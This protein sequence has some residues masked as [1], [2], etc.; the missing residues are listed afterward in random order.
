MLRRSELRGSPLLGPA[1][2]RLAAQGRRDVRIAVL[3]QGGSP[4]GLFPFHKRPG[5]FGRAIGAPFCDLQAM[6]ADPGAAFGLEDVMQAAGLR[7]LRLHA[8]ADPETDKAAEALERE[9]FNLIRLDESPEEYL[10]ARRS[11]HARAFKNFRRLTRVAER[12]RGAI[13]LIGPDRDPA[14]LELLLSWKR[15][16]FRASGYLDLFANERHLAFMRNA[17]ESSDP[18]CEGLLLTLTIG[19]EPVA[20]HFGVRSQTGYHP[21]IAAYHPDYHA[22]SPG[23]IF[24]RRAIEAMPHLG[25][26]EYHLGVTHDHYKK[27]YVGAPLMVAAGHVRA[28]HRPFSKAAG[29]AWDALEQLPWR[30]AASAAQ[31]FHRRLDHIAE[32]ELG[33]VRRVTAVADAIRT[34]TLRGFSGGAGHG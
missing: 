23:N 9:A 31:R 33:A 24:M 14:H 16:Q 25:L 21:W 7:A 15:A 5:G 32:A 26:R 28:P 2:T 1:F 30:A 6:I 4:V 11:E 20:G 18:G 29:A 13:E 17:F 19:G 3:R 27:N 34:Q 12:E 8:L 22:Y 10:E